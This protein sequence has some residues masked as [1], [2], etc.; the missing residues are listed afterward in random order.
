MGTRCRRRIAHQC[1]AP[2]YQAR[3]AE[4]INWREKRLITRPQTIEVPEPQKTRAFRTQLLNEILAHEWWRHAEF[5]FAALIVYAHLF[6]LVGVCYA[7]PG[8]IVSPV[9]RAQFVIRA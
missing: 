9:A 3:R 2:K 8:P 1:H 7:I 4:T 6:Q 5:V